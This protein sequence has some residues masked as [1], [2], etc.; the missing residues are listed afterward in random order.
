MNSQIR[1]VSQRPAGSPS[2]S[3]A[4]VRKLLKIPSSACISRKSEYQRFSRSSSFRALRPRFSNHWIIDFSRSWSAASR[5]GADQ[6]F[7]L[8]ISPSPGVPGSIFGGNFRTG[9]GLHAGEYTPGSGFTW[10]ED[11]GSLQIG[12]RRHDEEQGERAEG[13]VTGVI[14]DRGPTSGMTTIGKSRATRVIRASGSAGSSG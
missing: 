8:R 9:A 13:D 1:V 5:C 2:P 7:G 14:R 11:A 10:S 6:L 3:R 12:E 4:G